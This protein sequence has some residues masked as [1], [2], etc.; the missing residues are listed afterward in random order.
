MI[1]DSNKEVNIKLKPEHTP[2]MATA[3]KCSSKFGKDKLSDVK[4]STN[5]CLTIK[6]KSITAIL[7]NSTTS[8]ELISMLPITLK[9]EDYAN[10]EKISYLPR[11]LSLTGAPSG[12][13]PSVGDITYFAPWGNIA[14]IYKE[15][16]VGFANGFIRLGKIDSGLEYLL[17]ADS[18]AIT[19]EKIE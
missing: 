7:N 17:G 5:V 11:K 13:S 6:G 3:Q 12:H 10:T 2:I 18:S 19:I 4:P 8:K 9:L 16:K 1:A 14:I 15:S